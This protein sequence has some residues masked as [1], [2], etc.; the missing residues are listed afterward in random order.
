MA[1]DAGSWLLAAAPW[2]KEMAA[3]SCLIGLGHQQ[4][5]L[6][7]LIWAASMAHQ[8]LLVSGH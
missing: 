7:G 6:Y 2:L 3:S 8:Q 5:F 4:P 1:G